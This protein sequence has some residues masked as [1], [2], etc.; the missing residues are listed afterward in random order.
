[1]R[2]T[3]QEQYLNIKEGKGHKDVFLK[4]AKTLFPEYLPNY[5]TYN[6]AINILKQ[7]RIINDNTI[8]NESKTFNPFD[9]F[10]S[11]LTESQNP[12]VK[13]PK[14]IENRDTKA[15][16]SKLSKEVEEVQSETGYGY[17]DK[18]YIDNLYGEEFLRGY[19]VEL[20]D[21]KNVDKSINDLKEIVRKNLAK[22]PTFYTENAAFGVKG[23]GYI[24]DFPGLGEPKEPKGKWKSSGY[25]DIEGYNEKPKSNTKD[26]GEKENKTTQPK[27]VEEMP[28]NPK[29]LRGIK[30]MSS[31]GKEKKI[32]LQEN[33]FRVLINKLIKEELN[34]KEI[35]E[36][37]RTAESQ[38]KLKK[39]DEEIVRRRKKLKA[40][41]TLEEI[42]SGSTNPKTIKE[43]KND[44]KKLEKLKE[45]IN[46][47]TQPK[48]EI[49]DEEILDEKTE[50]KSKS[51]KENKNLHSISLTFDNEKGLKMFKSTPT[52]S[53][54]L[55]PQQLQ[56]LKLGKNTINVNNTVLGKLDRFG[57]T[58]FFKF[59]KN[60]SLKESN[61]NS[62][63][64]AKEEAQKISEEEGVVQHVNKKPDGSYEVSDW[65]D[66]DSTVISYEYGMEL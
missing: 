50:T 10:N 38:A 37:G 6:E 22:S 9:K 49:L 61:D 2:N 31:P 12:P 60:K 44:I 21:P 65:Y 63:S 13:V 14:P 4:H 16:N 66:A 41:T 17:R 27:K 5:T 3:L 26:L 30:K 46:K 42:E 28:T 20:R 29:S 7:K 59:E 43:L 56:N 58:G 34:L 62:L 33:Q 25:G 36:I 15:V 54:L 1:M 47:K 19:E 39:I 55:T 24:K 51:L 48:E 35:D 11:F 52:F 45:K 40:L 18:N 23:I 64:K 8:L 32:K 57:D 53:N